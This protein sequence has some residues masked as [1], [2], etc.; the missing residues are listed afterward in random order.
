M[1]GPEEPDMKCCH[2]MKKVVFIH[3]IS[4]K[5]DIPIKQNI[6]VHHE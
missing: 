4:K 1:P 3:F 5:L 2:T 6:G